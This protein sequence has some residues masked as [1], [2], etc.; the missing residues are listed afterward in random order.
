MIL[1]NRIDLILYYI[2]MSFKQKDVIREFFPEYTLPRIVTLRITCKVEKTAMNVTEN[3]K[4]LHFSSKLMEIKLFFGMTVVF[5][6][7]RA[8]KY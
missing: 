3:Y 2:G 8:L 6:R 5:P 4:N 7:H 1:A